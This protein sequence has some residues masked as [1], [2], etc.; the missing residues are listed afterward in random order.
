LLLSFLG[1]YSHPIGSSKSKVGTPAP[2]PGFS[3]TLFTNAETALHD[4]YV[5]AVRVGL[6]V[7]EALKLVKDVFI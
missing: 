1:R 6:G 2:W 4:S 3:R 7:F 5:H